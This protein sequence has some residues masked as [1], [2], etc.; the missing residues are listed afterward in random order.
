LKPVFSNL[1][2]DSIP[3]S[4]Q[5]N[6]GDCVGRQDESIGKPLDPPLFWLDNIFNLCGRTCSTT[7]TENRYV[8]NNAEKFVAVANKINNLFV[9]FRGR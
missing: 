1:K 4:V 6:I 5:R 2:H 7:H 8:N 3:L 9:C